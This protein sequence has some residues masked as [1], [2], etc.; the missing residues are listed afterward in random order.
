MSTA[1]RFA[2]E[3]ELPA[4]PEIERAADALFPAG[5]VPEPAT[6]VSER[7][8]ARALRGGVVLVAEH[9]ERPVGFAAC[10]VVEGA[11]HLFALAVHPA[12]GR[13]GIGRRLV[14]RVI[15]EAARRG[16]RGVTLTTFDDLPWN[17]PFYAK[18]GFRLLAEGERGAALDAVLASEAAA[19]LHTRVAML[20]E[21][22]A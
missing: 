11:L 1:I 6:T 22:S 15:E 7:A 5:R 8:L 19:G 20:R 17:A 13:R 3:A 16:L 9:G 2:L 21:T 12:S 10:D 4:L 18:L 14:E